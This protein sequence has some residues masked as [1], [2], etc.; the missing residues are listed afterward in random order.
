MIKK[1]NEFVN[2]LSFNTVR[3][4]SKK[5]KEKGQERRSDKITDDKVKEIMKPFIGKKIF[6]DWTIYSAL[7]YDDHVN[8]G[9]TRR[10]TSGRFSYSFDKDMFFN[11]SNVDRA[12]ARL[13]VKIAKAFNPDTKYAKGHITDHFEIKGY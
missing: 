12:S 7:Y 13:L 2:E 9:Y 5:M 6:D 1:W 4:A 11:V 8:I 3:S 10:D